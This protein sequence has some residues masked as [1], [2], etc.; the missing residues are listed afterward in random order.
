MPRACPVE[1]HVRRYNKSMN[2]A[3]L[4]SN[5]SFLLVFS[6]SEAEL[7]GAANV[8]LHGAS[9]WHDAL[10]KRDKAWFEQNYASHF[11]GVSSLNGKLSSKA[12]NIAD[13]IND[14]GTM[15][16]A[17]TTDMSVRVDGDKAIV[18]GVFR[19]KGR[20]EKG[21]AYDRR[22]RFIDTWIKRDGRWQAWASQ[23]TIIQ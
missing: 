23:G 14:K 1:P 18:I 15:E 20:D 11:T 7:L 21:Q 8:R 10:L 9:P 2:L 22:A 4:S 13:T 12:E 16:L 19:T 17:E 3:T 6:E 5:G